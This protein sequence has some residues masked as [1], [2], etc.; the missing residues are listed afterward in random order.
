MFR[1][2][3]FCGPLNHTPPQIYGAAEWA[4]TSGFVSII[5]CFNF[6]YLACRG[7]FMKRRASASFNL[8][9]IYSEVDNPEHNLL[10]DNRNH[11]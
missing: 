10:V 7:H 2:F 8:P 1:M 3:L 11:K 5:P 6:L 9:N 4:E